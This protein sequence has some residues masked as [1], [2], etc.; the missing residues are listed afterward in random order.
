[1][2]LFGHFFRNNLGILDNSVCLILKI[3]IINA[4]LNF[5]Y[6]YAMK[7]KKKKK[8]REPSFGHFYFVYGVRKFKISLKTLKRIEVSTYFRN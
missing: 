5:L 7:T 3:L 4:N 1:M 6:V 8:I 2:E